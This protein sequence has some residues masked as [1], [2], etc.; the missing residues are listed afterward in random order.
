M[1]MTRIYRHG[2]TGRVMHIGDWPIELP[3]PA[4]YVEDEADVVVKA[5][6]SR[7]LADAPRLTE[8]A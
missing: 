4:D 2:D 3:L 7:W 8:G 6:G 5:D 1:A